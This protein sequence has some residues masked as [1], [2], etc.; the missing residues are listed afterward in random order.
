LEPLDMKKH[1]ICLQNGGR[2]VLTH[3]ADGQT[4]NLGILRAV[5]ASAQIGAEDLGLVLFGIETLAQSMADT[6]E[7]LKR[8][9]YTEAEAGSLECL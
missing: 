7:G 3:S 1:T 9:S 2:L 6:R 4:L 8:I 5:S